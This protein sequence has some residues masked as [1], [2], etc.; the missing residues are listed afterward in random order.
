MP[1]K[2][3][4][5]P[6]M[7]FMLG[8]NSL[9]A[10]IPDGSIAPDFNATDLNGNGY[11]LYNLLDSGYTVFLDF[12]ATWC[13]PCWNYHNSEALKDLYNEYGPGGTN[14]VR[15][16]FLEGD[17]ATNRNC[18]FGPSGCVGGTQGNWV[19]GTP[20]PIIHA[21]G[22]SIANTYQISYF[23][24]IFAV[25][26]YDRKVWEAGQQPASGLYSY[27]DGQCA[28]PPLILDAQTVNHVKCYGTNTG[29]IDIT[30]S[31]GVPPYTYKWS[32]GA[33]TQDVNN[34][35]AGSY[36]VTVNGRVGTV[37]EFSFEVEQPS[38]PLALTLESFTPVGC[39]GLL[40][41]ATV[42]ASGGWDANYNYKWQNGQLGET[43]INLGVGNH[44]VSVTDD[45]LCI[46]SL[47]VNMAP[48]VYPTAVIADP[49]VITCSLPVIQLNG[50]GSS[51]GPEFTYQWFAGNG[52]NIV[53]GGTTTTATVDA[54][55]SYT[56]QVTN[57]ETTCA[58]FANKAVT[59]NLEQPT[60][61]AG[62]T[63]AI[64]CTMPQTTLQGSGSS[65]A[66]FSY[67]WTASNGGNIVSGGSSLTPLVNATGSYTLKVTNNINGCTQT[68]TTTVTGTSAPVL[69]TNGG[70]INCIAS[71]VTLTT[72]T[73]AASPTFEWT[74]PN[75]FQ[76]TQQSPTVTVSGSYVVVVTDSITTCTSTATANVTSNTS[77]PGATAVGNT[78]TCVLDSV[79]ISGSTPDTT[80]SFL[81]TGPDDFISTL[82]NPT[83]TIPGTYSLVVTDTLN[84]CTSTA[85]AN[86]ILDNIAPVA[87]AVSPGNLNCNTFQIQ[88]NGTG[89]SQG[90]NF[91]YSWTA[92]NGGHIISGETTQIPLVD[93]AGTYVILVTNT[94]NGCTQSASVS[95]IQNTNV[96]AGITSQSNVLCNGGASGS[97]TAAGSG[98]NG[99]F[100]YAWS[101]GAST[102][103]AE[104][105]VAG[106][107]IVV[108]TDSENCSA[109][110]SVAISQPD[111]LVAN[112]S[113]TAQ[114]AF[115]VSDGTAT[116]NPAGGT[117]S[118]TFAWNNGSTTQTISDLA[119]GNYTVVISDANGCTV[120]QTVTVNSFDCLLAATTATTGVS[121][122]GGN[123]GT[124]EVLVT[125][126]AAPFTFAW[127]NGAT[128]QAV[129]DL[130]A[131]TITVNVTDGNNCPAVLTIE[132]D[133]PTVLSANT[134]TVAESALGANDGTATA[135]PTGGTGDYT[136]LWNTGETTASIQNLTPGLYTV[137]VTDENGCTTEQ[138]V[139]VQSF[140][141]AISSANTIT[142]VSCAGAANGAVAVA[143]SGGTA[144][145]TYLWNTGETT[146]TVSNLTGGTYT[147]SISDANGCDFS[148]T[149]VVD[150]PLPF[151]SWQVQTV[152]PTCP[153]EANGSATVS[154]TGGTE[155][156]QFVWSNGATG[157]TLSNASVG[158]YTVQVTDAN[159]CQSATAV[160]LTSSDNLPPTV[161]AQNGTVALN[162]NGQASVSLATIGAQFGDNCGVSG[163]LISPATFDC[164]QIGDQMVTL[165]VTDL[166]GNTASASVMVKVVDNIVP[167]LTCPANIVTC[168]Y[169]NLVT[170]ASPIAEDNC[171]LAGNGQW[172]LDGPPSGSEFPIGVTPVTYS[173]EDASGNSG[174]CAFTVTVTSP[175]VFTNV[176]VNNDVNGQ[177]AGSIDITIEGG[178]GPYQFVWTDAS[179]TVIGNTEDIYGLVEGIYQVQVTDANDCVYAQLDIKLDNTVSVKE[180][181]W[182]TGVSIQPNPA[183]SYTNL[184]FGR[185]VA[186]MLEVV[187]IDGTG[188]ILLTD[189]SEQESVVRLDCSQL[190]GG[191]YTLRFR[192]GEEVGA[193]K[194]VINR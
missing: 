144:P 60:A 156:Y 103:T 104:G 47:T 148:T 117:G 51:S 151:S 98:G 29:S 20:Y 97:A 188:R 26:P 158:N 65:G 142:H 126:G 184:V 64:S 102:A 81:W 79:V 39:N 31:G 154:L 63:Q 96:I 23:P 76:S 132:I 168:S 6:I 27:V 127:S 37:A 43:A 75:G 159:G 118:Y 138:T 90:V 178:T 15:V 88:L 50:T 99:V 93:S 160:S 86:V 162:T 185:P 80:A 83:V 14:E 72:T 67:S 155:P 92:S 101:N 61:D 73:N 3:F 108:I 62:P 66:N 94:T 10:Q 58:S 186:G 137:I 113:A 192:T 182:L 121:C 130:P 190:P 143:L 89:S 32:N 44:I 172:D 115:G 191:V 17:A 100:Q 36:V 134:T 12:S 53:S 136:Y 1:I 171:L 114:S 55:G 150:E 45:N 170:Y 146:A 30:P 56:I 71:S 147:V 7:C 139:E 24:T 125:A 193:R 145:F 141:C 122:F 57:T 112:A 4:L 106:T 13:G 133:Q 153:N 5:L 129:S 157:N 35:A 70:E 38:A 194:L 22:P 11:N 119:P 2:K 74:G 161:S 95:L 77:A 166:S 18:L 165:I 9:H 105:L 120:A 181:A 84:G 177:G 169:D 187:V 21:Q 173:Y 46:V 116:A 175:V 42:A 49:Q 54:A 68:S 52:G 128:T 176:Q 180:P 131:G 111:A 189:I 163:T 124:A 33:T 123:N 152:N 78:L 69:V 164:Q 8:F 183:Q 149:A 179:G 41:I 28:P 19:A 107:Y 87:S 85:T 109:T 25:C 140:L 91:T 167:V 16:F 110:T 59:A 34:L 40:G 174:S 135:N 48:P 82:Q